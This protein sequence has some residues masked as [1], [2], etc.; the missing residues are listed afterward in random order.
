MTNILPFRPAQPKAKPG[1]RPLD[2]RPSFTIDGTK[3][4]DI[5]ERKYPMSKPRSVDRAIGVGGPWSRLL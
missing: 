4:Y 2:M 5:P 1:L 3:H